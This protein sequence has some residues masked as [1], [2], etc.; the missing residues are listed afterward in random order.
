MDS[1]EEFVRAHR[2]GVI[3]GEMTEALREVVEGVKLTGQKGKVV[4]EITVEPFKGGQ[5]VVVLSH[6][7]TTKAPTPTSER[8]PYYIGENNSLELDD[9]NRPRM[10]FPAPVPNATTTTHDPTTGEVIEATAAR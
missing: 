7:V 4:L 10:R 9:P 3:N 1:F 2:R 8:Q 6:K 5:E